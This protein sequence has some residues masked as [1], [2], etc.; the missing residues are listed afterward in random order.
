MSKASM[1]MSYRIDRSWQGWSPG[2]LISRFLNNPDNFKDYEVIS[3]STV[4]VTDQEIE[5]LVRQRALT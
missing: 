5:I 4:L 3:A 1:W 2:V